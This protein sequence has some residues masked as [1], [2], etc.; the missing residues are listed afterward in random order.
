MSRCLV[1][2]KELKFFEFG[3]FSFPAKRVTRSRDIIIG[4]ILSFRDVPQTFTILRLESF[5]KKLSNLKNFRRSYESQKLSK[6]FKNFRRFV[7][8]FEDPKST[9][10]RVE[11]HSNLCYSWPNQ[12]CGALGTVPVVSVARSHIFYWFI[13]IFEVRKFCEKLSSLKT[14]RI[15]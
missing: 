4:L 1:W 7:K 3:G 13:M 15:S 5:A 11:T 9:F 6:I 8:T 10:L 12:W 14:F 2:F